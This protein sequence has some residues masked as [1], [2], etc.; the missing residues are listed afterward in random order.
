MIP[1]FFPPSPFPI[2]ASLCLIRT[3]NRRLGRQRG[4]ELTPRGT[5][6]GARGAAALGVPFHRTRQSS[7]AEAF[8]MR[9]WRTWAILAALLVPLASPERA[10][11]QEAGKA[12][13]ASAAATPAPAAAA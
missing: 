4:Q 13:D 3:I 7:D 11:A 2:A 5:H 6:T 10:L 1:V 8:V 9:R 12:A